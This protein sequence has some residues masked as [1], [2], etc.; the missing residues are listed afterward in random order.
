MGFSLEVRYPV[1]LCKPLS[2]QLSSL[3]SQTMRERTT[4]G[5]AAAAVIAAVILTFPF[6]ALPLGA[7]GIDSG[8]Q[9]VVNIAADQGWAFGRDVVFA[10]GPLGWLAA[11]QDVGNH[12]L[13]ANGFRIA[14][15]GFLVICGLTV[16]F[17]VK[18]PV[19]ILAFAGLWAVAGAVG[20][21]F[22]GFVVLIVA[23]LMLTGLRTKAVWPAV[24]A[25]VIAGIVP[26]VK[27]S[28]GIPA[29]VTVVIGAGLIWKRRG[30]KVPITTATAAGLT[31]VILAALLFPSVAVLR[32][33]IGGA[34]EVVDGYAAAASIIGPRLTLAAGILVLVGVICGGLLLT[35]KTPEF[36]STALILAPGLLITFRLAFV[37]QD[38]HQ[39][40][41]VPFVV[42]LLGVA[43]LGAPRRVALG[44]LAGSMTVVVVGTLTGA[45]PFGPAA[46]PRIVALGH[47]GPANIARLV[48]LEHTRETLADVSRRNIAPLRLPTSWVGRMAGAPNGITVV[49]WELKICNS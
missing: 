5:I 14:L 38:G 2:D 47:H 29:A 31:A 8:W 7:P 13:L 3:I 15:Q 36:G 33:W 20:L 9:W 32:A 30:P 43:A 10:Y 11:P 37:R 24:A 35:R 28:L 41:F 26:F 21:R 16:L 23:L 39:F 34:L 42:A 25:G 17:R 18:Q 40:L 22:E 49:P 6:E 48:H 44:L 4:Q 46:L 12:L 27:T 45:L 1:Q 19:Q